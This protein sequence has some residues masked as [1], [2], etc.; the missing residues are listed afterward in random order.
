MHREL[1]L[2]VAISLRRRRRC[3]LD[4]TLARGDLSLVTSHRVVQLPAVP[5]TAN[6]PA[7]D[8]FISLRRLNRH[9]ALARPPTLNLPPVGRT[10]TDLP[11]TG[12]PSRT[13]PV[14]ASNSS[15]IRVP[16]SRNLVSHSN[17]STR[18]ALGAPNHS[19]LRVR[20]RSSPTFDKGVKDACSWGRALLD[21]PLV[22]S[23]H[24]L[25]GPRGRRP[26]CGPPTDSGGATSPS[27]PPRNRL[28]TGYTILSDYA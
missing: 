5:L 8:E 3:G 10:R 28:P 19:G 17:L 15:A 23:R 18:S 6:N 21:H 2:D 4:R 24:R 11:S 20:C 13:L 7:V 25:G 26:T 27:N 16:E 1:A 14:A 12:S 22:A 9:I